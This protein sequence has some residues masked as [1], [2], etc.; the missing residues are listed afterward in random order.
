MKE[1]ESLVT[2]QES[3]IVDLLKSLLVH[4]ET[5]REYIL[6]ALM[7]LSAKLPSQLDQIQDIVGNFRESPLLELQQ[8]S[9]EYMNMFK[10]NEVRLMLDQYH[11]KLLRVLT[12]ECV[13]M[14]NHLHKSHNHIQSFIF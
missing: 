2:V 4:N 8:R 6:T 13:V 9:C 7:K 12:L 1:G 14:S 10:Y 5:S 11:P 3:G